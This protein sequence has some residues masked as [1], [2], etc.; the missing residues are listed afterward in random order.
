MTTTF[1]AA[2]WA[3]F[4]CAHIG[5]AY[6]Q[7]VYGYSGTA[8]SN[9]SVGGVSVAE[10]MSR[11]SVNNAMRAQLADLAKWRDDISAAN[12]TAGS[13]AGG[14]PD[15]YTLTTDSTLTA[16]A[17]GQRLCFIANFTNAET[18]TLNVD[19]VGA[20]ALRKGADAALAAGDLVANS[21]YCAS[22]DA[23]AN[24]SAGAWLLDSTAGGAILT[25]AE[26]SA[27][28]GLT[29]AA[30]KVPYFTGSGTAA[31]A[32]FPSSVRTFLTTPSSANL[33]G[34]LSDEAGSGAA[35]FTNGALGTPASGTLT[36]ATGLP[37]STGVSGLGTGIATALGVNTGS[38]GAPVLFNGALGT[39]SSGTAT[40]ITGLPVS[41]GISGLG[42]GVATWLATPSTANFLSAISD[43]GGATTFL[44]A[45][46]AW[47][48]PSGAGDVVG[49][50]SS[51]DNAI[52]RFD[53]TTG[54]IIQNYTSNAPTISDSGVA[55]FVA[56]VLGAASATSLT[57]TGDIELGNASDTT[58]ARSS[59][60][61]VT[62][63]GA[64]VAELSTAQTFTARQTIDIFN[65]GAF[66]TATI[67]TG[68]ITFAAS[69]MRVDTEG[70]AASDD[71]DTISGG[72]DGDILIL[73]STLNSRDV[74]ITSAGNIV[75]N[76]TVLNNVGDR[77]TLIYDGILT[78]WYCVG[79][80]DGGA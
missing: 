58:I 59:A 73:R 19:S 31:L 72:S 66:N 26:I 12:T 2:L 14:S 57:T 44:R 20:K 6:A 27:L 62:I 7:G 35:Y 47:A 71:L 28:S 33:A 37:I 10:G 69:Y 77:I 40:N 50:A 52:A 46:G 78:A 61:T 13:A 43:E 3:V 56:P 76:L 36:N 53:G 45:D 16:Y 65:L 74:N 64:T 41:T 39:P 80:A 24:S 5:A 67:A 25:D 70:A 51:T 18:A 1:K 48:V 38:A 8:S 60:G 22:Y 30:D 55:T 54:K 32:D 34:V 4:L 75:C 79:T 9:T 17:D 68:A 21:T 63:E 23:S 29:S 15:P 49:P 11:A 42:S